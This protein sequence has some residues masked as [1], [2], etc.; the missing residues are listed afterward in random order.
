MN[1]KRI[2]LLLTLVLL[3][4][5]LYRLDAPG[6]PGA[7]AGAAYPPERP[8]PAPGEDLPTA[9]LAQA[10]P[11]ALPDTSSSAAQFTAT[12][13]PLS[14]D[15]LTPPPSPTQMLPSPTP[16]PTLT[17]PPAL[18]HP[19]PEAT[20]IPRWLEEDIPYIDALPLPTREAAEHPLRQH[21]LSP[22][23]AGLSNGSEAELLLPDLVTLPPYDLRLV[24]DRTNNRTL[25]RFSNAVANLGEGPLELRGIFEADTGEVRVRQVIYRDDDT[26]ATAPVGIFYFHDDHDHW[27]WDGFSLYE[28]WSILPGGE[29]DQPLYS[30]DKVGY[31]LRDDQSAESLWDGAAEIQGDIP[32]AKRSYLSCGTSSQGLSTGWTDVYA[33]DTPGQYVDVSGLE[34]GIYALRSVADPHNLIYE[35]SKELN[36]AIVY[37]HLQ[38]RQVFELG[39]VFP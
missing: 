33:H 20:A 37:F 18:V 8:W 17:P 26:A 23:V 10:G 24:L 36:Q 32:T 21:P 4:A 25:V 38:G 22:L 19:A 13:S 27:H 35:S 1:I 2:F 5:A 31:C 7:P 11:P 9:D 3:A 16:Q 12:P 28:V 29:L 15:V 34:D 39:Q 30:S 6:I 14:L